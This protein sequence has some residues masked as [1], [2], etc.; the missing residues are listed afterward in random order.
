MT[1]ST[2][3]KPTHWQDAMTILIKYIKT[4]TD[5]EKAAAYNEL[6]KLATRLDNESPMEE[7]HSKQA[8]NESNS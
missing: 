6:M 2:T 1:T 8:N 4:G 3:A 5:N 7:L